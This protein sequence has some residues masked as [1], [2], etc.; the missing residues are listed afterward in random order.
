M[1]K[2]GFLP[3]ILKLNDNLCIGNTNF[4]INEECTNEQMKIRSNAHCLFDIGGIHMVEWV[5]NGQTY[6][7]YYYKEVFI[8]LR[9]RVRKKR[10]DL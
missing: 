3:M 4:S 6:N 7:Q 10:Q 1:T 9:E 5:P 2:M 8:K